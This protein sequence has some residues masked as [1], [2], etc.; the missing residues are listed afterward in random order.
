MSLLVIAPTSAGKTFISYYAMKILRGSDDGILVYIAP[1]K[2]LVAQVAAEIYARFSKDLNW[3]CWAI[4]S[5]DFWV[6]DPQNCQI[7]VTVPEI[8]AIMLPSAPL[9]KMWTPRL[10]YVI[11]EEIHTIS[12]QEGGAVWQQILLLSPCPVIGLSAT[13]GAPERFN[14]WLES[15]Q[16]A[17]YYN[18][19]EEPRDAFQGLSTYKSTER[20]RFLHP[21]S[22]LSSSPR[23]LPSD[24]A[25]EAVDALNLYRAL[26]VCTALQ[27][28]ILVALDP[29]VFFSSAKLLQQKDVI[30]YEEALKQHLAPLLSSFDSQDSETPLSRI[31]IQLQDDILSQRA[32][33]ITDLHAQGDLPGIFFSFDRSDCEQMAQILNNVLKTQEDEWHENSPDWKHKMAQYEAYLQGA[34]ERERKG[35]EEDKRTDTSE[36][37][38]SFRPD[39]PLSDFSFAGQSTSYT[40]SELDEDIADLARWKPSP[41]EWALKCLRRGIAVHHAEAIALW[42][43]GTLALGINAPTKTSIFCG[44]SPFLTALMYRQCVG[45][46]GRRGYDTLGKVVFYALPMSRVQRLVLSKLPSL[47]ASFPV[48]SILVV[49]LFNLLEGSNYSTT[50]VT[51][52]QRLFR[53]P[54]VSF[55]SEEGRYQLL[56]HLRFSIDYLRRA[57][58]LDEQGKPLNLFGE[59]HKVFDVT[60]RKPPRSPRLTAVVRLPSQSR[61]L[62]PIPKRQYHFMKNAHSQIFA[63]QPSIMESR[64]MEHRRANYKNKGGLKQDDLGRRREEQQVEIRRQKREENIAKRRNFLPSASAPTLSIEDV[65]RWTMRDPNCQSPVTSSPPSVPS[66]RSPSISLSLAGPLPSSMPSVLPSIFPQRLSEKEQAAQWYDCGCGIGPFRRRCSTL[67]TT[68]ALLQLPPGSREQIAKNF[69]QKYQQ[70]LWPPS[71]VTRTLESRNICNARTQRLVQSEHL[72]CQ[73]ALDN[74][75]TELPT[76]LPPSFSSTPILLPYSILVILLHT[77]MFGTSES[78][79]IRLDIIS[80]KNLNVPSWCPPAGIYISINVDSRRR[81]KSAISVLSSEK[82]TAWGN[83]VTLHHLHSQSKS[84]CPM[85]PVRMLGSGEVIGKLELSWDDLLNHGD[86]PFDISF[87]PVC[88][89]HPSL[90]LKV[91]VVHA[92]N[93]ALSDANRQKLAYSTIGTP[94]HIAP[95][96]FMLK[97][98]G[99]ECDWWSLGAIFFE[100]V[101]GYAPFCSENPSDTYKKIIEWPN[102]LY[103]PEEVHL[104]QEAE[105][106]IRRC[107]SVAHNHPFFYGADWDNLRYIAPPFVPDELGNLPEQLEVVEQVGSDKDLAFL[108]FTFKRF[109]G[110]QAHGVIGI[111]ALAGYLFTSYDTPVPWIIHSASRSPALDPYP[112]N[113]IETLGLCTTA[114]GVRTYHLQVLLL[115]IDLKRKA[116]CYA[117]KVNL[118]LLLTPHRHLH[119]GFGP[120]RIPL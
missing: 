49:R 75:S 58:L 87:P 15:I 60:G 114:S 116:D 61:P 99:K 96:V 52:V 31:I 98:Y 88:G 38:T 65:H 17:F 106:L 47:S 53:L 79:Y 84:G 100:C 4:H 82:S 6:H 92:C 21:L 62:D 76:S 59:E 2:A 71:T 55:G 1:T 118:R 111:H 57:C 77:T 26:C 45:R 28:S 29:V 83:A 107:D 93:D 85:R 90:T 67:P 103:F 27:P 40:T 104:S 51:A 56:H 97:G 32:R 120:A 109:T 24:L 39:D 41:P 64:T 10:K 3:S 18:I 36:W 44:D 110:G 101:V 33:Q 89:V 108:G 94:D 72:S 37:Q 20:M 13:V 68:I 66:T 91:A 112:F 115:F 73:T 95:E 8:L 35:D 34:K 105:H 30:Q 50:A 46:A 70:F 63:I 81:W 16:K 25:L 117:L 42:L 119:Q 48:T 19:H 7:I 80:G 22:I 78:Q 12:Q 5:R 69:S 54:Q 11:L 23:S 86:E 43:R 113:T 14:E 9:A 74:T 102:Y